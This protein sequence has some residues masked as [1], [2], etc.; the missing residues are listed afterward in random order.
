MPAPSPKRRSLAALRSRIDTVDRA[1]VDLLAQRRDLV[2]EIA[3]CKRDDARPL[4]DPERER[5]LLADRR[6]HGASHGLPEELIENVFREV[7]R[8]SREHLASLGVGSTT[9]EPEPESAASDPATPPDP[10]AAPPRRA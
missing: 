5:E 9:T 1:I 8:A 7:L 3:A 10:A 6:A 2:T 4:R